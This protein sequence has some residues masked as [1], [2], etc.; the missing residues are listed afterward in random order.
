[1]KF[2]I[3]NTLLLLATSDA[4]SPRGTFG[5]VNKHVTTDLNVALDPP[6][7]SSTGSASASGEPWSP[8]SWKNFVAK[9]MPVYEDEEELADA[10]KRI[11]KCSPLVFAGEIRSLHEQLAR[12]CQG[13]GFLLMGGDCAE[14]FNEFNVDHIRDTFRVILQ[15]G[16]VLTF[17]SAMPVIKVGRM[18]GQF[19]K[20]RSE[21]DEVRDGVSLPSYRGDII[22][23]EEF[24][25]EARRNNPNNMVEAYHQSAQTLNILRAFSTGGY[26]DISRLHAW[27]LDFV[28]QTDEGSRYR[29][30]A[31]KVD[32]SLRF[33]KAIGVDTASPTFTKTDFYTAHE[34]LL[35]PY[36]QALTRQDSTTGR[37]YDCSAHMVWVGERTRDLDSAHLEF[38]RGIG[39]PLGVKISD[40]CTP[41][42]LINI[43]D[44]MNPQN[45][46]GRLTIVVRMGAEK[47]RQKLPG[48]IRAVQREGKSVLWISDPVHGNTRKTDNGYKT[49][50]FD[51][52]RDELRAFFDVHDE[53]GSHPG[54]VHLE[55]TG[56]D[57]TEC[58][59]GLSDVTEQS[60]EDRYHTYCDPRLNGAQALELAFLIAERMRVRTGLPSIE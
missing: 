22:N 56:E 35:L 36:E 33:M 58:V 13:Q 20:P 12:A 42:E 16:V 38:C 41:D 25:A 1:M 23:A 47:V 48:L 46:P 51:A 45:I 52:I 24:T 43:I 30:F 32:E 37:W 6:P 44:T 57:V 3:F 54:G 53:M 9:Q 31:T 14:A 29:K 28:E 5:K 21:P 49:R 34:C 59:G 55:M 27:N 50:D 8:T 4:F 15:M 2:T 10:V 26:A 11:E 40:K 60:L 18:A 19:A 7:T 39:N 17:G